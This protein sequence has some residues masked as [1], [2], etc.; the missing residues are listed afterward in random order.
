MDQSWFCKI[1]HEESGPFSFDELQEMVQDGVLSPD[2]RVRK[3]GQIWIPALRVAGLFLDRQES[4]PEISDDLS[5]TSSAATKLLAALTDN[6]NAQ[7]VDDLKPWY[8]RVIPRRFQLAAAGAIVIA[9][10]ASIAGWLSMQD[11]T[12]PPRI[13]IHVA[14]VD[15]DLEARKTSVLRAPVPRKPSIPGL[16]V[17]VAMPIPGIEDI[18]PAFSPTLTTDLKTI[19]YAGA[20]IE[21]PGYDLYIADRASSSSSFK[22]PKVIKGC[23]SPETE[24]YCT[25]SPDGLELIFLRTD[26]FWQLMYSRRDSRD[27]EFGEAQVWLPADFDVDPQTFL[28]S[29]PKFVGSNAVTFGR[30][31]REESVAARNIYISYRSEESPSGFGEPEI[32]LFE[33]STPP[34]TISVNGKRA[35]YGWLEGVSFVARGDKLRPFSNN[36]VLVSATLTG[37]VDGPLWVTTKE[38]IIFFCSPGPSNTPGSAR[39]LWMI[40]Y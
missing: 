19:V 23:S 20:G 9:F 2:D 7:P 33:D 17:S 30:R 13:E 31:A 38:D 40:R 4:D 5:S 28:L 6:D 24:A 36:R 14:A 25:L 11:N 21:G 12:F 22:K 1:D 18:A 8:Q 26:E 10:C 37:P 29:A 27:A 16:P 32:V 15:E 3:E 34:Y 35:Y 39:K